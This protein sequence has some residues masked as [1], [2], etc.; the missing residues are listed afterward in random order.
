MTFSA[1]WP[2]SSGDLKACNFHYQRAAGT[3]LNGIQASLRLT[4]AVLL[5]AFLVSLSFALIELHGA[6]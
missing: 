6:I 5:F 3:G 4:N 1:G 2:G